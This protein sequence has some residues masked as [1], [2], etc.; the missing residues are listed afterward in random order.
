[1]WGRVV[2]GQ[3]M[4]GGFDLYEIEHNCILSGVGILIS[5]T[6]L[7]GDGSLRSLRY[8]IYL[9]SSRCFEPLVQDVD[10]LM[11]YKSTNMPSK[12]K[13]CHKH[14]TDENYRK[15]ILVFQL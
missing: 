13:S 8:I 3:I 6:F 4:Y 1:M 11:N 10:L 9:V 2:W 5:L 15:L 14:G 7:D 12:P